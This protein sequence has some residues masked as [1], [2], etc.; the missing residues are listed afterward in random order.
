MEEK[1]LRTGHLTPKLLRKEL[2]KM[3]YLPEKVFITHLK[4]QY[5]KNIETELQR[6]Q[7]NNLGI[8]KDGETIKV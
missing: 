3:G 6:L 5:F 2:L 8:L 1:A 4:P 7:I